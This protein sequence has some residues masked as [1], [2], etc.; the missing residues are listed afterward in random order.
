M[1]QKAFIVILFVLF[2][3][4]SNLNGQSV[5]LKREYAKKPVTDTCYLYTQKRF[6]NSD[7]KIYL[8]QIDLQ[9]GYRYEVD[10]NCMPKDSIP[11]V[12]SIVRTSRKNMIIEPKSKNK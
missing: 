7:G 4:T 5:P 11:A 2:W 3:L 6:T 8:W 9:T 12:G 10:V 1:K